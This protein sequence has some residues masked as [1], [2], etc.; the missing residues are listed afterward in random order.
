MR[1][2]QLKKTRKWDAAEHLDSEEIREAYLKE[3]ESTGGIR[4]IE[5]AL[6]DIVRSRAKEDALERLAGRQ[7]L[8]R[9][10]DLDAVRNYNG[11]VIVGKKDDTP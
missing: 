11:P 1:S 9:D 5:A 4:M 6:D 7:V 3:A 8:S 2:L 10:S